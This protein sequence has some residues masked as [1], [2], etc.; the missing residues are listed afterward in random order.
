MSELPSGWTRAIIKK[1]AGTTGLFVDGDWIESKDQ[2]PNGNIR[3]LQLADIGDGTFLDKSDRW[4]NEDAFVRLRCTELATGD[5]L[6]ARMPDPL[7][8]ACLMPALE[9]RSV[10]VVDVAALR[11]DSENVD[12]R[13]VMH[14]IN[15]PQIRAEIAAQSSGTTRKRI[16]RG[17]LGE[18]EIPLPPKAEQTRIADQLD[19]LLARVQACNGHINSIPAL[20]KRFRQA[21]LD[22]A[23][24]GALT[25]NRQTASHANWRPVQLADVASDFSYGSA[26]KSSKIGTIPVLRMGNIQ[27]GRLD[28]SDLVYTSDPHE[29][30]KYK[31]IKGDVLFNRTNSPE[32]VGKTAVYQ[33][34]RDAIYAGYL[35]R[36]RCSPALLPEYLNYC[37]GSR[38]GRAYC[39][40]VK[41]DGVSQSNI[42]AKKLAAFRF[43]LPSVEEQTEIVRRVE[44][45]FK[46]ADRIEA[47]YMVARGQAQRLTSLLLAK[48]FRGELVP[49]DPNDEPASVLLERIAAERAVTATQPRRRQPAAGRK[50]ARAPK[51]NA[52]MTKSR[53]DDDVQGKPYLAKHLRLLGGS[54]SAEALFKASELPVADFYKQ[55]A[56]EVAQ[57]H[58]RDDKTVL[59]LADAA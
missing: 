25:E 37:L 11:V 44:A 48:A 17:R 43:S 50:P 49:P 55:L 52:A 31:L 42:N 23:T 20:L 51:E 13:W 7:G 22:A 16:S 4:I 3:L 40:S 8:R 15:S 32:L 10:T 38:A 47:R 1:L 35:I 56:W 24:S 54:A 26:A 6:I 53:Q 33:G 34:E 28:W 30:D 45:L 2:D 9:Q 46:L 14:T 18:M 27:N 58:L 36:V 21:V 39:W 19:K 57:G 29:I 41:S 5:V 12:N 59:E